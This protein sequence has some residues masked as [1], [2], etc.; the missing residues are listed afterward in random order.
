[1]ALIDLSNFD[2]NLVQSSQGREG[3][4]NGNIFFDVANGRVQIITAEEQ[5]TIDMTSRGGGA[6]DPNPLTQQDGVKYEALYAFEVEQRAIDESLRFHDP[7]FF[8]TFKFGGAYKLINGRKFDD[9]NGSNTSLTIDD[10]KKIRASGWIEEDASEAIGRIYYGVR[11]LANIEALSQGY[12]QLSAGGAPIDFDKDGP[13]DEAVQVFGD[14]AVDPNTTTFDS[15]TYLAIHIR[16]FGYT[17]DTKLLGDSGVSEM[18]GYASG[19]ALGETPHLTS[20]AFTLADVY[21]GAQIAPWTG[22]S[23]EQLDAPQVESGFNESD[24][25]FSWVL[26]NTGNG[27]LDQCIAFL[28]ALAQ[29]DDDINA[30]A[31]N[32]TNGKRVGTWYTY[33][34]QG[35]IVTRSGADGN[36]LFIENVPAADQ[37]R[38]VFTDDAAG[39][40]TRPFTVQVEI[41]VGANAIADPNAWYHIFF[42]DGPG[43]NDFNTSNA[44]TVQDSSSAEVK[45]NVQADAVGNKII[46]AFDYDGDT[47]GGDAGTDKDIVILVEGDGGATSAK[48]TVTITRSAIV[49]A[50]CAPGLETNL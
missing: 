26:H 24:G 21:G 2:S 18:R 13:I 42:L 12:H 33:D 36:G 46:F 16:T 4:P 48:T 20:G 28:D 47:L 27:T 39:L 23:L 25:N 35:R 31:S 44:I 15:R 17:Y 30:H 45:G 50:T 7:F 34:Q 43:P 14:A 38:I 49:A 22:M 11:S 6:N 41:E 10:R 40:K 37:Q 5:A 1:M 19:F 3:T 32:V 9:A 29:T 8:A